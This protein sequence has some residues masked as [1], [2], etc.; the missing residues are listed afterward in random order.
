MSRFAQRTD[1]SSEKS[2]ME[3]RH[4]LTRYGAD[5]FMFGEDHRGP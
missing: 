3:I 5:A 2:I 4:I 1:V